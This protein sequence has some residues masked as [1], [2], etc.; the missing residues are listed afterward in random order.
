MT[1]KEQPGQFLID[2]ERK[3]DDLNHTGLC[4]RLEKVGNSSLDENGRIFVSASQPIDV[5]LG[6]CLHFVSRPTPRISSRIERR[7]R[8]GCFGFLQKQCHEV[9]RVEV[10]DP[11]EDWSGDALYLHRREDRPIDLDHPIQGA[12]L[13]AKPP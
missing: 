12:E 8:L 4:E 13:L 5:V 7:D 6:K 2:P 1:Q 3:R 11:P 9:A 10:S